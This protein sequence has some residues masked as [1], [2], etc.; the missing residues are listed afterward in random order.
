MARPAVWVRARSP[1]PTVAATPAAAG[2]PVAVAIR[3][4]VG[5]RA[6]PATPRFTRLVAAA[7]A[8][9]VAAASVAGCGGHRPRPAA[10]RI[11]RTDLVV[12]AHTLTQMRAPVAAEVAVAHTAWGSLAGGLPHEAS[13]ALRALVTRARRLAA[14]LRLP[15][16]VLVEGYVTG[17]AVSLAGML[18][19][20]VRLSQRGWG[21]LAA[22]LA[23]PAGASAQ[24]ARFLRANAPLYIYCVYD[25]HYSL[26]L[27]GKTLQS[28]YRKLGGP[29]AFGGA[30][31]Q[32]EVETLARAYS[33]LATRLQPH[34][35]PS[36]AV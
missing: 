25:G 19:S 36:V 20:Y 14:A 5:N 24:S 15:A 12:L 11:E 33:I 21:Y 16:A 6:A 9:G 3:A 7:L 4:A 8:V 28:A 10:L 26:S 2:T 29:A 1:R 17:P 32:G 30:L 31:T 22:A 35:A 23:T 34:P 18:K 13:P 27:V